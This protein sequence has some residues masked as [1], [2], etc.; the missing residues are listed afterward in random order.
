MNKVATSELVENLVEQIAFEAR[1]SE[2]IDSKSGVSARLPISAY[3][4]LVSTAERRMILNN[5]NETSLRISDI[6]GI[7]PSITGKIELVYEGEQEGP[8]KVAHIL[9]SKSIRSIFVDHFPSPD[10]MKKNQPNNPYQAIVN[11]FSKGNTVDILSDLSSEEYQK[12]LN[13]VTGLKDLVLKYQTKATGKDQF[14]FMEFVLHGLAE[15]SLLSKF[16]LETGV[17]FKDMLS[18]MF[19]MGSEEIE[20]GPE[21]F[22]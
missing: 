15:Y 2:Y 20:G 11:W 7:I 13:K 1:Q 17:Q 10:K 14:L 8:T 9:I 4:S 19:T 22:L 6:Y 12:T 5:E 18:S 3:E 16:K 21:D